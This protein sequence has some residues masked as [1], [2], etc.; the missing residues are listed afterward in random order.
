MAFSILVFY[1][2]VSIQILHV[3]IVTSR[4]IVHVTEHR[5]FISTLCSEILLLLDLL[6]MLHQKFYPVCLLAQVAITKY[7]RLW[8]K[9]Q[10]F[11]SLQF[12]RLEV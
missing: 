5:T 7:N 12:W 10:K 2:I 1:E 3:R 4:A 6:V 11:I 8:L 9:Q